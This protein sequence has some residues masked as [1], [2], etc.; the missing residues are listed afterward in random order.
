MSVV[1]CFV[2]ALAR[3][4]N[5][6]F[7]LILIH[8]SLYLC[9]PLNF[10]F[11]YTLTNMTFNISNITY[12][13]TFIPLTTTQFETS[14]SYYTTNA[15]P[16]DTSTIDIT[17]YFKYNNII[18]QPDNA[19]LTQLTH[20]FK[21]VLN[22]TLIINYP[23]VNMDDILYLKPISDANNTNITNIDLYLEWSVILLIENDTNII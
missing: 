1:E 9:Q 6:I 22:Q 15:I 5:H 13:N 10:T 2:C 16:N 3:H 21:S 18:I 7:I 20:T 12:N 4:I 11:N 14:F 8:F 23:Q 17:L 19:L